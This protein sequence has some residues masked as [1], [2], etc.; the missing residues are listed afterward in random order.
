MSEENILNKLKTTRPREHAGSDVYNRFQIQIAFAAEMIIKAAA[1]DKDVLAF[2]D[3][4]D[5]VVIIDKNGE[6]KAIV[7][8]QVKT[9]DRGYITLNIIL[10]NEWFEKMFL[11]NQQFPDE[12]NKCVLVSNTGFNINSQYITDTQF[13]PLDSFLDHLEEDQSTKKKIIS[14]MANNLEV[15]ESEI[16]LDKFC[17]L[18][19]NLMLNDYER[20]I[21]GELLEFAKSFYPKLNAESIDVIY[22]KF[23]SELQHRQSNVYNPTIIDVDELLSRKSFTTEEFRG[24]IKVTYQVQIPTADQMYHFLKDHNISISKFKNS[25]NFKRQYDVFS[26]ENINHGKMI[27]QLVFDQ[28]NTFED[29][30]DCNSDSEVL[31]NIISRLNDFTQVNT[32]EFY[33][34]HKFFIVALYLYKLYEEEVW[35]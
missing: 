1:Q 33:N 13:V 11:N 28:I 10:K 15:N 2:V 5:D 24:L 18:K 31:E 6:S 34:K 32:T 27:C 7:F 30:F 17:L 26:V 3:Y 23:I 14:S 9:K 4:L 29:V 35:V 22:N 16:V 19:T 8:Y 12:T 25:I 20:Q 21:K